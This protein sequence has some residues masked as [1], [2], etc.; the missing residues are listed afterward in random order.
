MKRSIAMLCAL[1][2]IIANCV[3]CDMPVYAASKGN[4]N[5]VT[6]IKLNYA[7]ATTAVG[8]SLKLKVA[9]VKNE[10]ASKA[11]VWKSSNKKVA[12]VSKKGVV[13]AKKTG[14]VTITA[15]SKEN[16]RVKAKCKIKVYKATKKM[17]LS[18]KKNYKLEIGQI[19]SLR[20]RL[21]NLLVVMNQLNGVQ[22]TAI[23]LQ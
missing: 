4:A 10:K 1:A 14:T 13:K 3:I 21:Q 15:T 5:K 2:L 11:V 18:S 7:K 12:T 22:K 20:P 16:K 6:E 17:K 23:L 8:C 9:S 19:V